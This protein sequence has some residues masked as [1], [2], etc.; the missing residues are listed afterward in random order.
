MRPGPAEEVLSFGPRPK[1]GRCR[2]QLSQYRRPRVAQIFSTNIYGGQVQNLDLF[3]ASPRVPGGCRKAMAI[4]RRADSS[5][6]TGT[7]PAASE[8]TASGLAQRSPG[9]EYLPVGTGTCLEFKDS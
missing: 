5:R 2:A 7:V 4:S 3:I 1:Q 9:P 8:A 6:A